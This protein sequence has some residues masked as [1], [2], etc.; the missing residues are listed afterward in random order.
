[1][2]VAAPIVIPRPDPLTRNVPMWG[3]LWGVFGAVTAFL[4]PADVSAA[5]PRW[6]VYGFFIGLFLTSAATLITMWPKHVRG[7]RWNIR[8]WCALGSLCATYSGWSLQAFG[9][10]GFVVISLLLVICA[11][12][13]EQA[14]R[15]NAALSRSED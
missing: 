15:L 13:F 11:S 12:S 6:G 2:T 1:M 7:V 3:V 4:S 8:A 10:R 14:R 5:I 9:L